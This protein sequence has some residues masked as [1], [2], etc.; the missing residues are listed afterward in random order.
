MDTCLHFLRSVEITSL[1]LIVR[2][3][4]HFPYFNCL[5]ILTFF[6]K[7]QL[8]IVDKLLG[9]STPADIVFEVNLVPQIKSDLL[10][11]SLLRSSANH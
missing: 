3:F 2:D 4:H 1:W 8:G 7:A 5:F 10:F 6:R 9:N 11:Q